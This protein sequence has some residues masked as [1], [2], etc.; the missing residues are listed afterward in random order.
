[1]SQT[2]LS[3]PPTA[4]Q[5]GKIA[6]AYLAH[7]VFKTPNFEEVRDWWCEVLEARPSM[8]NGGLAF[9]TWDSEHH[10]VAIAKIPALSPNWKFTR[11]MDHVAFTYGSLEELL[12]TWERLDRIGIHPV[13]AINHGPTSSIYYQDP[14]GNQAELQVENFDSHKELGDFASGGDFLENPIGVDFDPADLLSRLRA[15]EAETRLKKRISIGPRK[16][17]TI[18][19]KSLG[20]L[21]KL[22]VT[23]AGK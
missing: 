10:R 20:T 13:W 8:D 9:L 18:P 4:I 23:L 14:D 7:I 21:H 3:V 11:G 1:M 19:R 16:I 22:L 15:G 2:K 12:L 17:G 6:P 5:R